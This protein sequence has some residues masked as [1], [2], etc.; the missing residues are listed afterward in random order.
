VKKPSNRGGRGKRTKSGALVGGGSEASDA[1][2]PLRA[3]RKMQVHRENETLVFEP[4]PEMRVAHLRSAWCTGDWEML[5]SV[6]AR[7][8]SHYPE[9]QTIALLVAA[10]QQQLG[11]HDDARQYVRMA[12]DWGCP[13]R[14]VAQI[15]V[16]GVHNTLGRATAINRDNARSQTHFHA[17]V[18][19]STS[20]SDAPL[21]SHVRSL[22]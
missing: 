6:N 3:N 16:A 13:P 19:P 14:L 7:E 5:A 18:L 4:Q 2:R 22:R 17:A 20:E 8:L 10:A 12:L 11:R 9:R 1:A 15:L 21:L